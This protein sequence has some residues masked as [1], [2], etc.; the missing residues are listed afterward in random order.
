[1]WNTSQLGSGVI[2]V[3]IASGRP[4]ITSAFA[5]GGDLIFSGTGGAAKGTYYVLTST[6]LAMPIADWTPVATNQSDI[7][8]NFS[9][10]NTINYTNSD[11]FYI[12]KQP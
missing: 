10:T 7:N 5:A 12:I 11:Q 3:A 2:I 8:G 1:M 9:T 6:N 4:V